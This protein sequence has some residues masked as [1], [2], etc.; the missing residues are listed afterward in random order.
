MNPPCTAAHCTGC[1]R[2]WV[3]AKTLPG[4]G[5]PHDRVVQDGDEHAEPEGGPV[6]VER[7]DAEHDEE[8]EV[9]LGQAVVRSTRVAEANIRLVTTD[10][11]RSRPV[12]RGQ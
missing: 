2:C 8:V 1:S 9:G 3:P 12:L 5:Q 7:D 4:H 10:S 6:L 11:I